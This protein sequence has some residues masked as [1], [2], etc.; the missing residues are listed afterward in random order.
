VEFGSI[1]AAELTFRSADKALGLTVA[2]AQ[3]L[4]WLEGDNCPNASFPSGNALFVYISLCPGQPHLNWALP[5][6]TCGAMIALALIEFDVKNE[7][8]QPTLLDA[9]EVRCGLCRYMNMYA[10]HD[11]IAWEGPLPRAHFRPHPANRS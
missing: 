7:A 8:I 2:G 9:L 10:P 3:F 6:R 4:V 11:L 5:C 1:M